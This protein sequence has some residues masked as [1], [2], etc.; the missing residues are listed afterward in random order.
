MKARVATW[1]ME[2]HSINKPTPIVQTNNGNN[3][4]K[5]FE[6]TFHRTQEQIRHVKIV[7]KCHQ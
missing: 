1:R 4:V 6:D 7:I 2:K 5:K 3:D